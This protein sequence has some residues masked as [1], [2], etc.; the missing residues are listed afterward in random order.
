MLCTGNL[1]RRNLQYCTISVNDIGPSVL[2]DSALNCAVYVISISNEHVLC[3]YRHAQ[4]IGTLYSKYTYGSQIIAKLK[5]EKKNSFQFT[6]SE[7]G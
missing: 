1:Y 7:E 4:Y 5:K 2:T 3:M 6:I